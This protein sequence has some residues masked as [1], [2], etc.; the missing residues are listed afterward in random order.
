MDQDSSVEVRIVT[1]WNPDEIISLY[2]LMGW[3]QDYARPSEVPLLIAGSLAFAVA[4]ERRTGRAVGTGRVISDGIS[5]AYI[6]DL[7]L[8]PEF[9][10]RGIGKQLLQVL[11]D[12]CKAAG[13]TWIGLIAEEDATEF[14]LSQGFF[15]MPKSVPM[16][17]SEALLHAR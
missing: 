10:R 15:P 14:Y 8:A 12:R 2:H 11:L 13:I 6:Q 3:W 1:S 16:L 9:R 17:Y 5:D 4:I 7:V